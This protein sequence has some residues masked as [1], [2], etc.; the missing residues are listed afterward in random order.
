MRAGAA[1]SIEHWIGPARNEEGPM[2]G[3]LGAKEVLTRDRVKQVF[4][5]KEY[6]FLEEKVTLLEVSDDSLLLKISFLLEYKGRMI[7]I[8]EKEPIV[9]PFKDFR[10]EDWGDGVQKVG[11]IE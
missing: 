5:N 9:V 4:C 11:D 1:L 8:E 10:I 3:F 6:S 2:A 7:S